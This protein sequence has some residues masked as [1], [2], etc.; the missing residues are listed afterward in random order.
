MIEA[1]RSYVFVS[2]LRDRNPNNEHNGEP[3]LQKSL[4]RTT[5]THNSQ[6]CNV[7][8]ANASWLYHKQILSTDPVSM[9]RITLK[10]FHLG[11]FRFFD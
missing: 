6:L 2:D 4:I 10:G 5:R 1:K 8:H 3:S 9:L 11:V 7:F